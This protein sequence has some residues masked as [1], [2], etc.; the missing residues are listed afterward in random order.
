LAEAIHARFNAWF[1]DCPRQ[2]KEDLDYLRVEDRRIRPACYTVSVSGQMMYRVFPYSTFLADSRV[3]E[4]YSKIPARMKLNGEV[5]GH[6]AALVCKGAGDIVDSN[7]GW[8]V[9]ANA[10]QKLIA[11]SKGWIS[12]RLPRIGK[13]AETSGPVAHDHPPCY[14]SWPDYGWYATNSTTVKRMWQDAS[15]SVKMQMKLAWG[16]DPWAIPLEQWAKTPLDFFRVLTLMSF[17]NRF[18][19]ESESRTTDE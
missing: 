14:A 15:D 19:L 13:S 12:R 6:A 5:W 3:A 16:S 17:L 11:F 8:S 9:N 2:L 7:F 1:E 4:C 10:L 18:V